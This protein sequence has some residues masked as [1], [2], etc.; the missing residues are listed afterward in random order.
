MQVTAELLLQRLR[1][2][3]RLMGPAMVDRSDWAK[4]H[5]TLHPG[6]KFMQQGSGSHFEDRFLGTSSERRRLATEG[7]VP[8]AGWCFPDSGCALQLRW[9]VALGMTTE[10]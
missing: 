10:F 1:I 9:A 2:L 4:G 3:L 7:T 5:M 8:W 6:L